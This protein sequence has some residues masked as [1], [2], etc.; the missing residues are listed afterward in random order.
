MQTSR[1]QF[2][3]APANSSHRLV[4][5]SKYRRAIIFFPAQGEYATLS[6]D[7]RVV[8]C[9]GIVLPAGGPPVYMDVEFFGSCVQAEWYVIYQ[10][11]TNP[12]A[13]VE[14]ML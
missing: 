8:S 11:G 7:P 5:N 6:N 9:K 12:V 10:T 4:G 14:V 2:D 3:P 13:F 1:V